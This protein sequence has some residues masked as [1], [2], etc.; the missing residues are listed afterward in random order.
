M[1]KRE[2]MEIKRA[3]ENCGE[4]NRLEDKHIKHIEAVT[5][6]KEEFILT[7]FKCERCKHE[8]IVQIDNEETKKIVS[9]YKDLILKTFLKRQKGETI[10]PKWDKRRKGY[11]KD[12]NV[13]RGNLKSKFEG[14]TLYKKNGEIF[15]KSLTILGEDGIIND[16]M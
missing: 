2:K 8:N 4:I 5:N 15:V 1:E 16:S 10:S 9:L 6:E 7:Y 13:K 14:K 11:T 3:C 12:L